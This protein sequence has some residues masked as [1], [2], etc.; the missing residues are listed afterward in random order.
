MRFLA[1]DKLKAVAIAAPPGGPRPRPPEH[2]SDL[3]ARR[4][5]HLHL[6]IGPDMQ[7]GHVLAPLRRLEEPNALEAAIVQVF[8]GDMQVIARHASVHRP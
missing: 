3:A 2:C 8:E 7:A 1:D 6:L 5:L 4:Y